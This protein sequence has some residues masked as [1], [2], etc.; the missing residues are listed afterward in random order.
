VSSTSGEDGRSESRGKAVNK[1][2][3]RCH[4]LSNIRRCRAWKSRT[5]REDE[6]MTLFLSISEVGWLQWKDGEIKH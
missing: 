2:V 5:S 1:I 4:L 6:I 3:N